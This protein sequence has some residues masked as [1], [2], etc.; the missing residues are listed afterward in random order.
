MTLNLQQ[1]QQA[2]RFDVEMHDET[3]NVAVQALYEDEQHRF[4]GTDF[5]GWRHFLNQDFA[6]SK[7][8]CYLHDT[9]HFNMF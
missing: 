8:L 1:I 9:L 4:G 3:F 5:V 6:V 2:L 7:L